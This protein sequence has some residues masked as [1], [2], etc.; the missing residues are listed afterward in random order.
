MTKTPVRH[1]TR[2]THTYVTV[3]GCELECSK[4]RYTH[5][6]YTRVLT[7]SNTNIKY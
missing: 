6:L 1:V 5:V 4:T 2:G 3:T 7:R